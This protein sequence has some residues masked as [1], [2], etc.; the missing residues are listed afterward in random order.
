MTVNSAIAEI[1]KTME[2][3]EIALHCGASDRSIVSAI[4]LHFLPKAQKT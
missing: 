3:S 4:A 1:I 2:G